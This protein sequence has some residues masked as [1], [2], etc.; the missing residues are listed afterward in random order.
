M[1]AK[2]RPRSDRSARNQAESLHRG[3]VRSGPESHERFATYPYSTPCSLTP[4]SSRAPTACHAAQQAL[5]LRPIM[6]LL[7][8]ASRCRCRLNSNVRHHK[9]ALWPFSRQ[10]QPMPRTV[11]V[12]IFRFGNATAQRPVLARTALAANVRAGCSRLG[13][14]F[15]LRGNCLGLSACLRQSVRG[16]TAPAWSRLRSAAYRAVGWSAPR[17]LQL[18]LASAA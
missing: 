6:R 4:R 3:P 8:S 1:D 15:A 18:Q 16:T 5:G 11:Q 12:Q 13:F 9:D 17:L 14:T 2:P 10:E 7:V